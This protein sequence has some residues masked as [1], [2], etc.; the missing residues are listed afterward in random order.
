[1]RRPGRIG[2]QPADGQHDCDGN[3]IQGISILVANDGSFSEST[4]QVYALPSPVLGEQ[5]NAQPICN[6]TN[7]CVLY[8]GQNQNDFT[9][10][11]V[12]SAPFLD[13]T[14][15]GHDDDGR[16]SAAGNQLGWWSPP[17][18]S[19][20]AEAAADI[21]GRRELCRSGQGRTS[22]PAR[23]GSLADTGPAADHLMLLSGSGDGFSSRRSGWASARAPG[24]RSAP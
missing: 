17:A 13:R 9:A 19:G 24:D 16:H 10:P 4:Y 11:K 14:E 2:G 23:S 7:Y 20:T 1:M 8:V 6:Q 3:T 12:F 5:P 15:F 18:T 21:G 22:P